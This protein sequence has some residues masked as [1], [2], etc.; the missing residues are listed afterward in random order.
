VQQ[1]RIYCPTPEMRALRQWRG[2]STP[3][4]HPGEGGKAL[5]QDLS[6]SKG[7]SWVQACKKHHFYTSTTHL[8]Q[9]ALCR[10]GKEICIVESKQ[11]AVGITHFEVTFI[12]LGTGTGVKQ[13]EKQQEGNSAWVNQPQEPNPP[14]REAQTSSKPHFPA[15]ISPSTGRT[16]HPASEHKPFPAASAPLPLP[17]KQPSSAPAMAACH[18][19]QPP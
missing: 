2:R 6:S 9:L 4:S 8:R 14:S 15:P 1:N 18:P 3:A 19:T 5:Q 11:A 13:L 17:G 12:L 7:Q 16:S 10:D